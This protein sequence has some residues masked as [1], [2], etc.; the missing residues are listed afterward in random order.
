MEEKEISPEESLKL[1]QSMIGKARQNYTDNSIFFLLW[2]WIVL[3]A[4]LTHYYL[5]VYTSFEDPYIGW[6]LT[7]VGAVASA[8]IGAKKGKSQMVKNYMD[9]MYGWLWLSLGL[10]MFT[11]IFN[12]ELV[13]WNTIPF[14]LLFAG[15]GTAVSG[16]MMNFKP[17][18]FG[19]LAFWIL[20][21][22][23]F[24]Q[25]ENDQM[26]LMALGVALGYLLPGYIMRANSKKHGI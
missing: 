21:F 11:I 24:R 15:V 6:S 19:A 10:A 25:S 9:K 13:G 22:I 26:L 23:A 3:I 17:M 1:I 16:A 8:V 4:S 2:G 14:I 12:G 18:Q 7:L 20:S 5:A